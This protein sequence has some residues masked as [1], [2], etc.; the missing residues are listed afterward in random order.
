MQ[1]VA[2]PQGGRELRERSLGEGGRQSCGCG[3]NKGVQ[4]ATVHNKRHCFQ[5]SYNIFMHWVIP[6][7]ICDE[8]HITPCLARELELTNVIARQ[9][10][11]LQ[12]CME[13]PDGF[14]WGTLPRACG[15]HTPDCLGLC[16]CC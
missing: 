11:F 4:G 16:Q 15:P 2:R 3:Y 10:H 8:A 12:G 5:F 14:A 9:I 7:V 1:G 6:T 13:S